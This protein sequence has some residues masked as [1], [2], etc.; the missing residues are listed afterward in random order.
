M[1]MVNLSLD[2]STNVPTF[3]FDGLSNRNVE[4]NVVQCNL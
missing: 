1:N 2:V 3:E 4:I